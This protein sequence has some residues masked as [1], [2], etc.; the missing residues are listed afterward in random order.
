[1]PAIRGND[2]ASS[3]SGGG[4]PEGNKNAVGN[5]GGAPE[6][7]LNAATHHGYCDPLKHYHRLVDDA[8]EYADELIESWRD[9]Y[10]EYHDLAV[11][12]VEKHIVDHREFGSEEEVR[13]AFRRLAGQYHL[14]DLPLVAVIKEGWG[15]EEE[16][17]VETA[18]GETVTYTQTK[19]HPGIEASH[20]IGTKRRSLEKELGLIERGRYLSVLD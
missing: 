6:G 17:E 12:E 5:D 7:N 16:V 19:P 18:E 20:R 14:D 4:A 15:I 1:M 13:D 11:E 3:N 2:Y 8:R 9:E 10:A